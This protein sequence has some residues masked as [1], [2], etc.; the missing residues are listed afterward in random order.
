MI[1]VIPILPVILTPLGDFDSSSLVILAPFILPILLWEIL[2]SFGEEP[3]WQ[4]FLLP[5][6]PVKFGGENY[7]W[8]LGLIWAIWH[9][10]LVIYHLIIPMVD[11]SISVIAIGI[12]FS[13]AGHTMNLI[14]LTYLYV[15]LYNNTRSVFLAIVFH[16]FLNV[17]SLIVFVSLSITNE[18]PLAMLILALEPGVIVIVL[19]KV[20]CKEN[21][22]WKSTYYAKEYLLM[23]ICLKNC[24]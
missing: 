9:Y 1:A 23:E 22:S 20:L 13:L 10:P 14:G 7:I 21:F 8:I 6:L 12:V 2:I 17:S 3:G 18:N 24:K 15:W 11:V 5:R 19:T 4:G 16:G